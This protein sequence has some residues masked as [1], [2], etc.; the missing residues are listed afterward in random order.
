[1]PFDIIKMTHEVLSEFV[2]V[3]L[4]ALQQALDVG[5]LSLHIFSLF[6]HDLLALL[7]S[8]IDLLGLLASISFYV[9]KDLGEFV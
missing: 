8:F 2:I 3:L 9:L 1:M 5:Y 7:D 4:P 6:V